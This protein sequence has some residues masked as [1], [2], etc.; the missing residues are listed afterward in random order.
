MSLMYHAALPRV[1]GLLS[2]I[3]DGSRDRHPNVVSAERSKDPQ[4][5]TSRSETN[6]RT[7]KNI[8]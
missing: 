2:N 5:Q 1:N 4:E 6:I 8:H 3:Y 7:N